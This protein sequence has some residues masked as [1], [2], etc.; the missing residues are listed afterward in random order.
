MEKRNARRFCVSVLLA[1]A[2]VGLRAIEIC[3]GQGKS[4]AINRNRNES[5]VN[6]YRNDIS[7]LQRVL[8]STS[9]PWQ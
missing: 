2:A 9:A 1:R 8:D 3:D 5:I 7:L 6:W 4:S